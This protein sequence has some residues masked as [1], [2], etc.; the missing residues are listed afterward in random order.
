[1]N[2]IDPA[3]KTGADDALIDALRTGLA[4]EC[5]HCH[6]LLCIDCADRVPHVL[7]TQACPECADSDD[8]AGQGWKIDALVTEL[9]GL[10]RLDEAIHSLPRE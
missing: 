9:A 2:T 10:Q 4:L 3:R 5:R 1:M 6:G 8:E 7:C